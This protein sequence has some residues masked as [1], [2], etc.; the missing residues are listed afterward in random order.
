MSQNG[1]RTEMFRQA[2]TTWHD[3][4]TARVA[5]RK[6]GTGPPM[7]FL[8][9]WPLW[10]FT[11]R[12]LLPYLAGRFTCYLI[13]VPGGGDTLWTERTNFSWPGQAATVKTL[14]D[15]LGLSE[16]HL[17]GQDSGAMIARQL[18]LL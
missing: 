8:H 6:V 12:K 2:E 16:Y 13:D 1:G 15:G 3:T 7:G 10:G 17:F 18:C 11:F 9:G 4:P 5:C 14:V